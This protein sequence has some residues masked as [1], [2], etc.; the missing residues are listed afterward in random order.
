MLRN[1][2]CKKEECDS[3]SSVFSV[4]PVSSTPSS[5]PSSPLF[6]YFSYVYLMQTQSSCC[7]RHCLQTFTPSGVLYEEN[8]KHILKRTDWPKYMNGTLS[9]IDQ[10]PWQEDSWFICPQFL[11]VLERVRDI[12]IKWED[13]CACLEL[14]TEKWCIVNDLLWQPYS[15]NLVGPYVPCGDRWSQ[16]AVAR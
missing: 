10:E 1:G 6:F 14:I 11:Q 15:Y 2:P 9:G 4:V 16:S 3:F 8:V 7:I 13:H 5:W 12:E